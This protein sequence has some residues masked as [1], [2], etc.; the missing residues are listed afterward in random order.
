MY[1]VHFRL[2]RHCEYKKKEKEQKQRE[3]YEKER[4]EICGWR[5]GRRFGKK[6]EREKE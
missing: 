4:K 5:F 6:R 1:I 3:S 2:I